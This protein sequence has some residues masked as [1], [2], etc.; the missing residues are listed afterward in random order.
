MQSRT[1]TW[2]CSCGNTGSGET[3]SV[4]GTGRPADN[5]GYVK[6]IRADS[7]RQGVKQPQLIV[8]GISAAVIVFISIFFVSVSK[9]F[10]APGLLSNA[11]NTQPYAANASASVSEKSRRRKA[12]RAEDILDESGKKIGVHATWRS[13]DG[14]NVECDKLDSGKTQLWAYDGDMVLRQ[15]MEGNG[16]D[17]RWW[18]YSYDEDGQFLSRSCTYD[19]NWDWSEKAHRVLQ[20]YKHTIVPEEP[21]KNCT[22]FTYFEEITDVEYGIPYG[23]FVLYIKTPE[24]D[25]TEIGRFRIDENIG[26][27]EIKLSFDEPISFTEIVSMPEHHVNASSYT[28]TAGLYDLTVVSCEFGA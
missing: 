26:S 27:C 23:D 22:G 18:L 9:R 24:G 4:C 20:Y 25:W 28:T 7:G 13:E 12:Y 6:K 19:P 15:Y 8:F 16:G 3:C 10:P 5:T 1:D 21:I 2:R 17:E 11:G 14:L